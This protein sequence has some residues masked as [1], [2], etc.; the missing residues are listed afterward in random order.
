M[1][2]LATAFLLLLVGCV[3]SGAMQEQVLKRAV[4]DLD[5]PAEKL[6][7]VEIE[8][9]ANLAAQ[10][11]GAWGARG[12]GRQATYVQV[13]DSRNILMNSAAPER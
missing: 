5:C 13:G 3:T 8:S 2:I 7:V 1:K 12:C 10:K 4:F 6:S 11:H 9:P